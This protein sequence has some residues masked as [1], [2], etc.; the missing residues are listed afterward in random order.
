LDGTSDGVAEREGPAQDSTDVSGGSER[1][2][3]VLIIVPLVAGVLVAAALGARMLLAEIPDPTAADGPA[4]VTCWDGGT[5]PAEDCTIPSGRAGLRWVFPSFRP[6]DLDCR[7][8]LRERPE[9]ERP[10]MFEC[11]DRVGAG[12]VTL[13]YSEFPGVE[14]GRHYLEREY[15]VPPEEVDDAGVRRLLWT[16][17]DEPGGAVYELDVMYA[18]VPFGVE[19]RAESAKARDRA[20]ASLV[21]FRPEDQISVRP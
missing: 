11:E 4:D 14:Q 16:E 1:W 5:G 12:A 17:G 19:V 18:E 20:L 3:L 10:V 6:D 15:G 8:V 9:L 7:N 21:E 13:T 2:R